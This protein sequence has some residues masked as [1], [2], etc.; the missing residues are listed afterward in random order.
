[1]T[2]SITRRLV[3]GLGAGLIAGDALAQIPAATVAA[4]RLPLEN[5]ATLRVLRPVRFVQPDEEVFRA[6]A[7]RFTAATG[8]PVRVDFVA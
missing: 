6:N 3:G 4:P 8:V 7:A 1:M 5:G 2:F